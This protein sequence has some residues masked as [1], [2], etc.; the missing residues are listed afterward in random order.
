MISLAIIF[1]SC[2]NAILETD[3][4]TQAIDT[5]SI[6][7]RALSTSVAP[8]GNFDLSRWSLQLPIGSQGS[9]TTIKPAQLKG[10]SG[11]SSTYFYTDKTDGAMVFMCP[12]TGVTTSGS[13]HP[14]TE[15]RESNTD[16]SGAS[17]STSKN[18][19]M[20]ASVRATLI[21]GMTCIGQIFQA[22]SANSKPL[23]ELFYYKDGTLKVMVNQTPTGGSGV[24]YTVG[25]VAVGTKFDYMLSLTGKTIKASIN[26]TT[27]T[28]TLPSGYGT[29]FYFKAG[30]YDQTATS[31][32][33]STTA[34]SK[35][36]FYS[37][38]VTHS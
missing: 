30:S 3:S 27:K 31:G 37:L 32:S 21:S 8:G 14:R 25:N 28:L 23:L 2:S 29:T 13:S 1:A 15:F 22:N 20:T 26:G 12:K 4:A 11:Y 9:P 17:W 10:S 33:I 35:V 7:D 18:N 36:K 5:S 16:G 38:K 34:S 6:D 19:V 24:F